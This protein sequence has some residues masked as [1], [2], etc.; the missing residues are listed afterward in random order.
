[1]RMQ[2]YSIDSV[3]SWFDNLIENMLGADISKRHLIQFKP[4]YG[5]D[6]SGAVCSLLQCANIRILLD[7]GI[8]QNIKPNDIYEIA[9]ELKLNGGID[10]IIISHGDE[11]HVRLIYYSLC[12]VNLYYI[13]EFLCFIIFI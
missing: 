3:A 4:L 8:D 7:C 10:A 2:H 11:Q 13:D 9:N 1:M 6:G 12:I 5:G